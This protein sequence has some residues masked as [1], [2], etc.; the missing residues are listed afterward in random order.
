MTLWPTGQRTWLFYY[1]RVW[2]SSPP[3][4][5]R[6]KVLLKV[7]TRIY[8]LEKLKQFT[9]HNLYLNGLFCSSVLKCCVTVHLKS[10]S[11]SNSKPNFFISLLHKITDLV[12]KS[13]WTL[14]APTICFHHWW[15]FIFCQDNKGSLASPCVLTLPCDK[16][17]VGHEDGGQSAVFT[18]LMTKTPTAGDA[19][20]KTSGGTSVSIRGLARCR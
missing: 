5:V 4:H 10:V 17:L 18:T 9:V 14:A 11:K 16:S 13:L 2:G 20:G 3:C 8:Q 15:F 12:G 6:I 1:Q 7:K 19:G